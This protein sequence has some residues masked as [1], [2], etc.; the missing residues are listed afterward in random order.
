[1]IPSNEPIIQFPSQI[2]C[3]SQKDPDLLY[4]IEKNFLVL[5]SILEKKVLNRIDLNPLFLKSPENNHFI[6]NLIEAKS[7]NHLL[8]SGDLINKSWNK[9][10]LPDKSH[11]ASIIEIN[12]SSLVN[13][14]TFKDIFQI[15]EY[16][17]CD[18]I[19]TIYKSLDIVDINVLS[20]SQIDR[21]QILA[22]EKNQYSRC[23][24]E[25]SLRLELNEMS[26]MD[27]KMRGLVLLKEKLIDEPENYV[28]ADFDENIETKFPIS[29]IMLSMDGFLY[30]YYFTPF[31]EEFRENSL[32]F[33]KT[34]NI[35]KIEENKAKIKEFEAKF[36][37]KPLE[38]KK[39]EEEKKEE[40]LPKQG[41]ATINKDK[42]PEKPNLSSNNTNAGLFSMNPLS[43]Q[44]IFNIQAPSQSF[45]NPPSNQTGLIP[46]KPPDSSNQLIFSNQSM[47]NQPF[48][49]QTGLNVNKPMDPT[50]QVVLTTNP[51]ISNQSSLGQKDL[52]LNKPI[53]STNQLIFSNQSMFNQPFS[54]QP[55]LNIDKPMDPTKQVVLTNPLISNQSSLGQKDLNLNKPMESTNQNLQPFLESTNQLGSTNQSMF[56]PKPSEDPIKNPPSFSG[57]LFGASGNEGF[58][59]NKNDFPENFKITAVKPQV[60]SNET[61]NFSINNN[62]QKNEMLDFKNNEKPNLG[63]KNEDLGFASF[64]GDKSGINFS[65]MG[66]NSGQNNSKLLGNS[67]VLMLEDNQTNAQKDLIFDDKVKKILKKDKIPEK[68]DKILEKQDKIIEKQDKILEKQEKIPEKQE[69]ILEKQ[70]K[71]LQKQD[72]ILEKQDKLQE[73]QDKIPENLL[74]IDEEEEEPFPPEYQ[75]L[76]EKYTEIRSGIQDFSQKILKLD[77]NSLF[78]DNMIF[79]SKE[80]PLLKHSIQVLQAKIEDLS[81]KSSSLKVEN[82]KIQIP[83]D[84]DDLLTILEAII[85][86]KDVFHENLS[87]FNSKHNDFPRLIREIYKKLTNSEISLDF[88]NETLKRIRAL[89]Q[90][91]PNY[92]KRTVRNIS[93]KPEKS[94]GLGF[95]PKTSSSE[96]RKEQTMNFFY[97]YKESMEKESF[98]IIKPRSSYKTPQYF[99]DFEENQEKP[100]L[101]LSNIE[102][103]KP[104]GLNITSDSEKSIRIPDLFENYKASNEGLLLRIENLIEKI[105][106]SHEKTAS[107]RYGFIGIEAFS[108]GEDSGTEENTSTPENLAQESVLYVYNIN[109][110]QNNM[111]EL[112]NFMKKNLKIKGMNASFKE[113]ILKEPKEE[114]NQKNKEK[115]TG[116]IRDF[117]NKSLV[118]DKKM[119]EKQQKIEKIEK[120]PEKIL[121]FEEEKTN[122]EVFKENLRVFEAGNVE[123]IEKKPE[124][125]METNNLI[126]LEP[127]EDKKGQK[128]K[129]LFSNIELGNIN[130]FA[131]G[132]P[133]KKKEIL[134]E[135][136]EKIEK[137]AGLFENIVIGGTN[138]LNFGNMSGTMGLKKSMSVTDDFSKNF[139]LNS[140]EKNEEKKEMKPVINENKKTGNIMPK[141]S[142][143]ESLFV[144]NNNNNTT[145]AQKKDINLENPA[146]F[147]NNNK[148]NQKKEVN[149]ENPSFLGNNNGVFG[150][151]LQKPPQNI[152]TEKKPEQIPQNPIKSNLSSGSQSHNSTTQQ[153]DEVLAS[154][155]NNP[156]IPGQFSNQQPLLSNAP[157]IDNKSSINQTF[158]QSNQTNQNP[159]TQPLIQVNP[160]FLQIFKPL[161]PQ[162]TN[163][164]QNPSFSQTNP[165]FSQPSNQFSQSQG[166]NPQNSNLF[167]NNQNQGFG[168][169]TFAPMPQYQF[170]QSSFGNNTGFGPP[171][172]PIQPIKTQQSDH[173]FGKL[174]SPNNENNQMLSFSNVKNT[175]QGNQG[176]LGGNTGFMNPM[177]GNGFTNN[178]SGGSTQNFSSSFMQPRK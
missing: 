145:A 86:K 17:D 153:T 119:E 172:P 157:K 5:F 143:N 161:F 63:K 155:Q 20:C 98:S 173:L 60:N 139:N 66:E 131:L 130:S 93:K 147:G 171:N 88:L 12:G 112:I 29:L 84:I 107:G 69:K 105:A 166:F 18:Y 9:A 19:P 61:G 115:K 24:I 174:N 144:F 114:E 76:L 56:N 50:K 123:K 165:T 82:K 140:N 49:N 170:G 177:S 152:S 124:K 53:D 101:K 65:F 168:I 42:I 1:M 57:G 77:D 34:E 103:I 4:S 26:F 41:P 110:Q 142:S 159:G 154:K 132:N 79:T 13:L 37:I 97:N 167:T 74:I 99:N 46:N 30:R 109:N 148:N 87:A 3:F 176:F 122:F 28:I 111:Q 150:N 8:I 75:S 55:G 175:N 80:K 169:N 14:K 35:K 117:S 116:F 72:K 33:N 31:K 133:E 71:I 85:M 54:N 67:S 163:Q 90:K 178:V 138:N 81:I 120:K 62:N 36:K 113:K 96:K 156:Q 136:Q 141:E 27:N 149:L 94:V 51:L 83:N 39:R 160:S 16:D 92:E 121:Q 106:K 125:P 38:E 32:M 91:M 7:K 104:K 59:K 23:K 158:P 146:F 21:I 164:T 151:L 45:F 137:K 68:Q 162:A 58:F 108:D 95:F 127:K 43:S 135:K 52:N 48:S 73:K 25:G 15:G 78:F 128:P 22:Y 40:D 2:S 102:K 47:F 100:S 64:K 134:P 89:K 11:F 126:K 70:D 6:N 129:G 118:F 44:S 10:S